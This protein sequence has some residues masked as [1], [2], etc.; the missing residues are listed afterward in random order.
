MCK[1]KKTNQ[2]T[3]NLCSWFKLLSSSIKFHL[4]T[5][6]YLEQN[7]EVALKKSNILEIID[8]VLHTTQ[9]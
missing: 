3:L 2:R 6:F 1:Q 4:K 5:L 7:L 9:R 8:P